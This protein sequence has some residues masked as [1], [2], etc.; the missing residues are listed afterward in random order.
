MEMRP[1]SLEEYSNAGRLFLIPSSPFAANRLRKAGLF[2]VSPFFLSSSVNWGG[3]MSSMRHGVPAL[4]RCAAI[5]DPITPAPSTATR[6]IFGNMD[7]HL[8]GR[9]G[10]LAITEWVFNTRYT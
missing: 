1:R 3:T 2:P 8:L 4:A 5:P 10:Q 9:Y 6:R 7:S